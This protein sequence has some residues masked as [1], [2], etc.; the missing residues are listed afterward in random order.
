[1]GIQT[2]DYLGLCYSLRKK[3]MDIYG[4]WEPKWTMQKNMLSKGNFHLTKLVGCS[5]K[6]RNS[7]LGRSQQVVSGWAFGSFKGDYE[8]NKM[9]KWIKL[10]FLKIGRPGKANNA[11]KMQNDLTP[12][13]SVE[14]LDGIKK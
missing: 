9:E 12:A 2:Q 1:M 10:S 6:S 11:A 5:P 13:N 7:R 8:P 14:N 3:N 4:K